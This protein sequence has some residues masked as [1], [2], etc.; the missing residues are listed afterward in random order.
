MVTALHRRL[1]WSLVPFM[2]ACVAWFS[3]SHAAPADAAGPVAV[4]VHRDVPIESVTQRE[5]ADLVLGRQRF[6]STGQRVELVIAA[7]PSPERRMFV[8]RLS[9]MSEIQ[10]RQYWIGLLFRTR[11]TSAPRAAP[12]RATAL[13]LVA[14]IPGALALV[15]PGPLPANVKLVAVDGFKPEAAQYPLR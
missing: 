2:F 5:L 10:F 7:S 11:A 3:D 4:V 12:D 13:A 9:G 15:A 6:W 1:R 14:G 8:E